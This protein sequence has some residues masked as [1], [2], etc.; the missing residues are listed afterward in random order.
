MSLKNNT[1]A[2]DHEDISL[3]LYVGIRLPIDVPSYLR[4]KVLIYTTAET[5]QL[6]CGHFTKLRHLILTS[7]IG[8][9][10]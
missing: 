4:S 10:G 3:P 8:E 7:S 6:F 1:G 9:Q 2:L 5:S